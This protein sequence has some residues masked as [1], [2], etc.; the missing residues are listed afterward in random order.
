MGVV[1]LES[2]RRNSTTTLPGSQFQAQQVYTNLELSI[3]DNKP[4]KKCCFHSEKM[5]D[6]TGWVRKETS[7]D[8][9]PCDLHLWTSFKD[10]GITQT[11][12]ETKS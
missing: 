6:E 8:L 1:L 11:C 4:A 3:L 7:P 9:T 12:K 5:V 2:I 10:K